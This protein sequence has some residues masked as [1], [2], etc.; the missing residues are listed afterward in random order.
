VA[1][2]QK[3]FETLYLKFT[4]G[5]KALSEARRRYEMQGGA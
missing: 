5:F 1:K 3:L 4:A 2:E